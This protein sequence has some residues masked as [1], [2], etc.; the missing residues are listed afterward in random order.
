MPAKKRIAIGIES[1]KEMIDKSYYYVDKTRIIQDLLDQGSKVTL[2]TRPRRFGKT[3]TLSML[4]TFFEKDVDIEG[5]VVDYSHY[6]SGMQIMKAGAAYTKHMGQ[7]PVI[8]LSLKSAKQPEYNMAY[9][10]IID[11]VAGEFKRHRYIL[12]S[13]VL[14]EDEYHKYESLMLRKAGKEEYAT[15]LQ[16]LAYCLSRYHRKNVIVLID[17]YDV[18]LE[19]AYF[20]GFYEAMVDFI[21]SLFESVLKTNDN[22]EFAVITGCLRISKDSIFTGLN[23]LNIISIINNDYAE[24][25]GFDQTEVEEMLAYYGMEEKRD[26]VKKWYDG[27]RFGNAA[28]YN[29]WS[30]INYIEY[31]RNNPDAF[32]K[33]YWSNTSSNSIVRELIENADD[34]VREEIE[35]LI[36]GKEIEKQIHEDITYEDIKRTQDNLWN[37]LFFTGYLKK[38]SQRQEKRNIYFSLAIPNEEIIYIYENMI[39][40]WFD[41]IIR[42]KDFCSF[43]QGIQKGDAQLIEK[44]L[45]CI[46]AD[47]ISYMDNYENFYHGLLM[48]I[49]LTMKGYKVLSNREAG[50]GRYDISLESRDGRKNPVILEFKFTDT[51][52]NMEEKAQEALKQI[53]EK[54][55]D[56]PFI[57]EGYEACVHIGIGFCKKMCRVK[58]EVVALRMEEDA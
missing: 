33:P 8:S 1:Y 30:V 48:G 34:T 43:F 14:L 58:C 13:D 2:F 19:N 40:E 10:N 54:R 15:A 52:K 49:L 29:P 3:L 35:I 37:F 47:S 53:V 32:P 5:K 12:K 56:A 4:R 31:G 36:Q 27:Y 26:E 23:N 9:E 44:E 39:R 7:Y 25:F 46:L 18:P 20:K 11:C 45:S 16:F 41:N 22:L 21:R 50:D 55:Y 6:F 57:E 51:R 42:T 28:V 17:E 38:V 24:Y